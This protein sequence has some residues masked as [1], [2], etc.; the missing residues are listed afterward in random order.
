MLLHQSKM[1]S[2]N[3]I[4]LHEILTYIDKSSIFKQKDD[5]FL[6]AFLLFNGHDVFRFGIQNS[7]PTALINTYK[8]D[9]NQILA[10]SGTF[11]SG[12]AKFLWYLANW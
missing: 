5:L 4:L 12:V 6:T 9:K 8:V 1:S 2:M 10:S 7:V 3:F 11:I